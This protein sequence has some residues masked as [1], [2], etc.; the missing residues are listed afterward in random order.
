MLYNFNPFLGF[1]KQNLLNEN[2]IAFATEIVLAVNPNALFNVLW[3]QSV[4]LSLSDLTFIILLLAFN[5]HLVLHLFIFDNFTLMIFP[6]FFLCRYQ[7]SH[8]VFFY[9]R[10][11]HYNIG[12]VHTCH[13]LMSTIAE[14]FRPS[15]LTYSS[16]VLTDS[17][18]FNMTEN[19]RREVG[20]DHSSEYFQTKLFPYYLQ[21]KFQIQVYL[22]RKTCINIFQ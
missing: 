21:A 19:L 22:L 11:G 18:A 20:V 12:G 10:N 1:L 13:L 8:A 17:V 6:P 14:Y 16:F 7:W 3:L 2:Q 15:N 5:F 4:K 9:D